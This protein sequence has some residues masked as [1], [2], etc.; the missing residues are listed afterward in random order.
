M[1]RKITLAIFLHEFLSQLVSSQRKTIFFLLIKRRDP[2][3]TISKFFQKSE[4]NLLLL[5]LLGFCLVFPD[6]LES[7]KMSLKIFIFCKSKRESWLSKI[8]FTQNGKKYSSIYFKELKGVEIMSNIMK[9]SMVYS[10]SFQT[11]K[12]ELFAKSG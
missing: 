5:L 2:T 4:P 11:S 7:K 6:A 12:M 9:G 1:L 8:Y 3:N 10:E